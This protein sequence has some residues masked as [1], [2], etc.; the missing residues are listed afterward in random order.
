MSYEYGL[1]TTQE[2][3]ALLS[4]LSIPI[5]E[6]EFI[7]SSEIDIL[8]S[9]LQRDMGFPVVNWHWGFLR[10]TSYDLAYTYLRAILTG[11]SGNIYIRTL[12]ENSL[13]WHDYY[14]IYR[15]PTPVRFQASRAIDLT[16][17][18]IVLAELEDIGS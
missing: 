4:V 14:A 13:Y 16:V 3:I 15:F 6:D 9:G 8:G 2:S 17:T 18:F 7:A 1:G 11:R 12:D 10:R 5:P